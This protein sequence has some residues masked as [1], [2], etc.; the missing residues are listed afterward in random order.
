APLARKTYSFEPHQQIQLNDVFAALYAGQKDRTNAM[1]ML[2]PL[3]GST[4]RI[5]ALATRI[6]NKTNDTK[7]L[8]L[9][10]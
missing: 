8:G 4:G 9:R 2:R 3:P 7:N 5:V 6:D 1:A 10:P